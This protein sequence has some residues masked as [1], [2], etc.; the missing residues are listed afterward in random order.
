MAG[1]AGAD[2][3]GVTTASEDR[4]QSAI[5]QVA[6]SDGNGTKISI[7]CT[8][9]GMQNKRLILEAQE[10]LSIS[11]AVSVQYNDAMFLGEVMTCRR[12]TAGAWC[13]EIKVEQ[14]LTGL[15]SL[16]ALR[17]RLLGEGVVSPFSPV[18]AGI[19]K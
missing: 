8:F 19:A 17:S 12:E 14:I 3:K 18:L 9:Q 2:E 1:P 13:L 11:A 15:E 4:P 10:R 5:I 16:M 7:P 6:S